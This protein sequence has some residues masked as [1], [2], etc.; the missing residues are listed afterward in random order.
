M[1]GLGQ[2]AM[3]V[4]VRCIRLTISYVAM[5]LPTSEVGAL[6]GSTPPAMSAG[7]KAMRSIPTVNALPL[8]AMTT[9]R[10]S[11]SA[12]SASM[13]GGRS[14]HASSPNAF[15]LS[16]R[17]SQTVATWSA[18]STVKTSEVGSEV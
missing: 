1:T 2:S 12:L 5:R 18:K 16:G 17:S 4:N 6:A 8:A 3:D 15:I 13:M 10:T 11:V 9:T 14:F 7:P